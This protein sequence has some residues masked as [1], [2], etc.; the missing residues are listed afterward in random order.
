MTR[1]RTLLLSLA[2]AV[3]LAMAAAAWLVTRIDLAALTQ[4]LEVNLSAGFGQQV[5]VLGETRLHFWPRPQA[6]F[7]D[8]VMGEGETESLRVPRAT[9]VIAWLPLL[10]GQMQVSNL[11]L[12]EPV[13][14]VRRAANGSFTPHWKRKRP[15]TEPG[16][17]Q[18]RLPVTKVTVERG[19]IRCADRVTDSV[20]ELDEVTMELGNFHRDA[21]GRLAFTGELRA[22][23]L[24]VN[25]IE[26]RQVRGTLSAEKGVYRADPMLGTLCG[27]E[28]TFSLETDRSGALPTW[29]LEFAAERLSLA[30]LF[31][32]LAGRA[33][34]EGHVDVR[35]SLSATGPG[36]LVNHLGGTVDVTGK[37][38][39]QHGFDL[40]GFV[41][42]LRE[43]RQVDLVDIGAY[44]FVG[45]VGTLLTRSFDLAVVY[46]ELHDEKSQAIEQAIFHWTIENGIARAKDVALRTREN[47]VAVRGAIDL[48]ERRYDGITLAVL[49]SRGCAE[50]TEKIS[51]PLAKPSI[52][53]ISMLN[54]LAGPLAWLLNKFQEIVDPR[55]CRPFY[56]GSV[57]HPQSQ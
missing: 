33:L 29:R 41:R 48:S 53:P 13:L 32:A 18:P 38:L 10:H 31:Q 2:A 39:T 42:S 50:L 19:T 4:R 1:K 46:R 16:Q 28:A 30:E 47:R 49:D 6:V 5:K 27:S 52:Q 43:S 36:R 14:T 3:L 44:L 34:Y 24:R 21:D 22:E 57:T 12:E 54:T 35:M 26:M 25:R 56:E 9:A 37:H 40:D 23:R 11:T 20:A 45:P 7:T 17:A 15:K 51:G 8:I 55:E